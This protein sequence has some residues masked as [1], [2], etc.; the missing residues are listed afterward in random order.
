M[1]WTHK[2]SLK[3]NLFWPKMLSIYR[4]TLIVHLDLFWF[5]FIVFNHVSKCF[6]YKYNIIAMYFWLEKLVMHKCC[7]LPLVAFCT[8]SADF[9]GFKLTLKS[10]QISVT[11]SNTIKVV[12]RPRQK[13]TKMIRRGWWRPMAWNWSMFTFE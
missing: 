11:V 4:S 6:R 1:W 5:S 8:F 2:W 3:S 13:K 9:W 7:N 12:A 10:Y